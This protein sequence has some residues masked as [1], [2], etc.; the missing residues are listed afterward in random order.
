MFFPSN[1]YRLV[2]HSQF[3]FTLEMKQAMKK[4]IHFVSLN[5]QI[6]SFHKDVQPMWQ[7]T[8]LYFVSPQTFYL[9]PSMLFG[10]LCILRWGIM[11]F[12]QVLFLFSNLLTVKVVWSCECV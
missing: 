12:M 8:C 4:K 3:T 5:T 9:P 1:I 10:S 6:I 2:L 11:Y 7:I